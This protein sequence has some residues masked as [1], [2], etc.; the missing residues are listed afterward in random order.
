MKKNKYGPFAATMADWHQIACYRII[1]MYRD[2]RKARTI[3]N[4]LT[5]AEAQAHCQREDT[6]GPGWFDGYDPMRGVKRG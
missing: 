1:R 5:E 6:H 2:G 3:K 4:G